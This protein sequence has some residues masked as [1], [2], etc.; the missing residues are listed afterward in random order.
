MTSL[1]ALLVDSNLI[2]SHCHG[3][4]HIQAPKILHC[5]EQIG[6]IQITHWERG[7]TANCLA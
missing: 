2:L 6:R 7:M 1:H 4:A 3:I 5:P